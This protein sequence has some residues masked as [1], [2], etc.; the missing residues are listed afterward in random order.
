MSKTV[1][2]V[3][4]SY[5][6]RDMKVA[7][8]I[9]AALKEAGL[10][11][12]IDQQGIEAGQNFPQVLA[13][14]IDDSTVFLFLASQNSFQSKFTRGEVTYAFNHKHS[15]TIIP[16]IIDGSDQ[17]PGDL[18]L[19]LG[20]FNWR[21]IEQYPIGEPLIADIRKAIANPEEGT[22]GGR[23]VASQ[24]K[25]KALLWTAVSV[26]ALLLIAVAI[27]SLSGNKDKKITN[28]AIAEAATYEKIIGSADSLLARADVMKNAADFIETT[29][30]QT[31]ILKEALATLDSSDRLKQRF[32]GSEHIGMFT[33][34]NQVA[35]LRSTINSKLDSMF[36]AWKGYAMDSYN[37]YKVTHSKSEALNAV[38]CIEHALKIK[39]NEELETLKNNLNQQ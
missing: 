26:I 23:V 15:G 20:N 27:L 2:D 24:K 18:E 35:Q 37:L 29:D 16:Y 28:T 6:R 12:F 32:V 19:M 11:Y 9:C 36:N 7:Q 21:R 1:Y 14:A 38:Q 17:M 10:T 39:P 4:I 8:E 25:K 5:S 30:T 33:K 3:F 34:D 22:V 31:S 13:E